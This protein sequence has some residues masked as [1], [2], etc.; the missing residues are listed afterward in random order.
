MPKLLGTPWENIKTLL[1]GKYGIED[2]KQLQ[3][4]IEKFDSQVSPCQHSDSQ[5]LTVSPYVDT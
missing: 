1:S 5:H 4:N 2:N 3:V